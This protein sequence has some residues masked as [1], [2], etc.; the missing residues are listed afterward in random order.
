MLDVE[1]MKFLGVVCY[2]KGGGNGNS[3]ES[4]LITDKAREEW[5]S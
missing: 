2:I 4:I 3:N 1:E 5:R